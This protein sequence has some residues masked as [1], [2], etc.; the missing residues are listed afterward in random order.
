MLS[1]N[2]RVNSGGATYVFH[3]FQICLKWP[4]MGACQQYSIYSSS[5]K[6]PLVKLELL[7][8]H[9]KSSL[10]SLIYS[11]VYSGAL[12]WGCLAISSKWQ[13][14]TKNG[15]VLGSAM[16]ILLFWKEWFF[17]KMIS[18]CLYFKSAKP[19]DFFYL[20]SIVTRPLKWQCSKICKKLLFSAKNP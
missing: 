7:S 13:F 6:F 2:G 19:L 1:R 14:L 12:K 9:I 3:I 4:K 8:H 11:Y 15:K 18:I 17:C 5:F 16:E 20:T 10:V